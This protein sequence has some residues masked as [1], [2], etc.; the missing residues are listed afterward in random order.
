LPSEYLHGDDAEKSVDRSVLEDLFVVSHRG[1]NGFWETVI[2][3]SAWNIVFVSLDGAG[4]FLWIR[5]GSE[6]EPQL[7][8]LENNL[9]DEL[10]EWLSKHNKERRG[11]CEERIRRCD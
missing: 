10:G 9:H 7:S 5:I 2:G 1:D 6:L 3:T 8:K 4:G 11:K